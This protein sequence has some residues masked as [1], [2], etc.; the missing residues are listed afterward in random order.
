M[1]FTF[2]TIF[3]IDGKFRPVSNFTARV[4]YTLFLYP[5]LLDALDGLNG[6]PKTRRKLQETLLLWIK[7]GFD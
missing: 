7:L 4:R 5:L 6:T 2:V 1:P 3:S